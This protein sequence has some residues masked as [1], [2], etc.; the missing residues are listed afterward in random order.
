MRP[1][2][3]D[4]DVEYVRRRRPGPR[5]GTSRVRGHRRRAPQRRAGATGE[6]PSVVRSVNVVGTANVLLAARDAGSRR[7]C[8]RRRARCSGSRSRTPCARTRRAGR[9]RPT[10]GPSCRRS[11]CATRRRRRARREIVRPRTILGHG[12]LGIFAVLF[13]FVADGAPVYVLGGGDNRYQFVH[14]DDLA[15][16]CLRAG[17]R[18]GPATYNIGARRVRHDARDDPGARRSRRHRLA[19][20]AR[21]RSGRRA[22][23]MQRASRRSASRRSRPTTGSCT[24]SR[25]SSTRPRRAPSSVGRPGTRTHRCSS[26][27]TSGTSP[28][29]TSSPRP[30]PPPVARP[31]RRPE[32]PPPPPLTVALPTGAWPLSR[33][34]ERGPRSYTRS[35]PSV[36]SPG[37]ALGG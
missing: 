6:G 18:P 10:D 1:R 22:A 32:G 20:S 19:R 12:R 2:S 13:E 37:V 8:T 14:A 17:D 15:D 24:A 30:L 11:S 31:P 4:G 3:L 25:C 33:V 26:S 36:H 27:R 34:G 28:I 5:R 35:M 29:A 21:S 16:A 23:A 9:S 7:S